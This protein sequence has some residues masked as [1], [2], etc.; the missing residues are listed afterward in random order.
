M[1]FLIIQHLHERLNDM[2]GIYRSESRDRLGAMGFPHNPMALWGEY[3]TT[4]E[5]GIFISVL[6]NIYTENF[7]TGVTRYR[8]QVI[9]E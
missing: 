8:I 4:A 7:W 9:K 2:N 3:G 6:N 1:Y 5:I